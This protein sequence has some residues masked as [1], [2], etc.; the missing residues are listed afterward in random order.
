ME[1]SRVLLSKTCPQ[2]G[3]APSAVL[4]RNTLKRWID[5]IQKAD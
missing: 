1:L 3:S 2:I 4:K 5:I